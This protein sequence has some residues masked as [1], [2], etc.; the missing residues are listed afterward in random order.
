MPRTEAKPGPD[1]TRHTD[2][3]TLDRLDA[4][5]SRAV[6][7]LEKHKTG[8]RVGEQEIQEVIDGLKAV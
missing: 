6:A 8:F 2:K 7:L 1:I 4:A 5:T 3:K